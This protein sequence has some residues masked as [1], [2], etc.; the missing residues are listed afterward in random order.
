LSLFQYSIAEPS[1][2]LEATTKKPR[3][4]GNAFASGPDALY[5]PRM[6]PEVY[7]CIRDHCQRILRQLFV[8]VASPI[9]GPGKQDYGDIDIFVA[10]PRDQVC[11]SKEASAAVQNAGN[12]EDPLK[13]AA[14]ILGVGRTRS[15]GIDVAHFAM[16]W[17]PKTSDDMEAPDDAPLYVQVD[18]RVCPSVERVAW[19]LFKDCHGDLWSLLGSMIR[20]FGLTVDEEALWLRIPEIE[21]HDRKKAKIRLTGEPSEI[22]RFLG[23]DPYGTEWETKFSSTNDL[24]TYATSCRFFNLKQAPESEKPVNSG[25]TQA[26]N[27]SKTPSKEK[28]KIAS[29]PAYRKFVEE[30]LP[31]SRHESKE[32]CQLMTRDVIRDEAFNSFLGVRHQYN[33]RLLAWRKQIQR[34]NLFRDVIQPAFPVPMKPDFPADENKTSIWVGCVTKAFKKVILND[35]RSYGVYPSN[36]LDGHGM[37]DEEEIKKFVVCEFESLADAAWDRHRREYREQLEK[38][39]P[40]SS[41]QQIAAAV[42]KRE[43]SLT[44]EADTQEG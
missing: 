1:A 21:R 3:M 18:V 29:R 42:K 44:A 39:L 5:T 22:L 33:T 14:A 6:P 10:L 24:F 11:P 43:E 25:P 4:G 30:F 40:K 26:G 38:K 41:Q 23:L 12:H 37:F 17:P 35:D 20:P 13:A 34:E 31:E 7:E 2:L 19:F 9:E 16:P 32:M 8:V 15:G 36:A 27:T 28:K